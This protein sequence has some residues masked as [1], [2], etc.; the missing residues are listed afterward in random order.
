MPRR[1]ILAQHV[2]TAF[3]AGRTPSEI[4]KV[5]ARVCRRSRAADAAERVLFCDATLSSRSTPVRLAARLISG[6]KS[7]CRSSKPH[8]AARSPRRSK[9]HAGIGW[10]AWA[11]E[12]ACRSRRIELHEDQVP[13]LHVAATIVFAKG[14]GT[15]GGALRVLLV[16]GRGAMSMWISLHDR[17]GPV[18]PILPRSLSF[19]PHREDAL[20]GNADLDPILLRLVVA[21]HALLAFEDGGVEPILVDAVKILGGDQLPGEGNGFLL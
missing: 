4:K 16:A 6:M 1:R 3:I 13:Y 19:I 10:K 5:T 18:S 8:L 9:S 15:S 21:R 14:S 7:R 17:R 11:T 2:A 20:F 12:S